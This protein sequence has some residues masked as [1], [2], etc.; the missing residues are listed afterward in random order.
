MI[1]GSASQA[2]FFPPLSQTPGRQEIYVVETIAG[3]GIRNSGERDEVGKKGR[4]GESKAVL[5]KQTKQVS[6]NLHP[7]LC[8][9]TAVPV[10]GTLLWNICDGC[11]HPQRLYWFRCRPL[12]HICWPQVCSLEF[13]R[14]WL[15]SLPP[16]L[17][18]KYLES[19]PLTLI[20]SSLNFSCF[21]L[22]HPTSLP[23]VPTL[24]EVK[25]GNLKIKSMI[26]CQ[27]VVISYSYIF[28]HKTGRD[29][30]VQLYP[31]PLKN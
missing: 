30:G 27:P 12:L 9:A 14:T 22:A 21:F 16:W 1:Q 6:G 26:V 29:L 19:D 5:K 24:C 18:F 23:Q 8:G 4:G 3:L 25:P 10:R 7:Q 13:P 17:F 20:F 11:H 15:L 31:V 2:F 28:N